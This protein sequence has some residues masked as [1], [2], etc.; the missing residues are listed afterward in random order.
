M[1]DAK[2]LIAR[3]FRV[4]GEEGQCPMADKHDPIGQS[5]CLAHDL[6]VELEKEEQ[7]VERLHNVLFKRNV[8]RNAL[9]KRVEELEQHKCIEIVT[10]VR[11]VLTLEND[12]D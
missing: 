5:V 9:G 3:A 7:E 6:A 4:H 1:S 11:P 10:E 12:R 8:Q 2:E